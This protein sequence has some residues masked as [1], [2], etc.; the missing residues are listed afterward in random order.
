MK[1][2]LAGILVASAALAAAQLE[3]QQAEFTWRGRLE[4]GQE[5]AIRGVKGNIQALPTSEGEA[6]VSAVKRARRSDPDDVRIE[7]VPHR[8]GVTVCA[9]YPA[10]RRRQPNECLPGGEGRMNTRDNDV[11]VDFTVFVPAGV[12]FVGK[13]VLG[14]V[15]AESLGGWVRAQTVNGDVRVSTGGLAEASTVNGS[16]VAALGRSDWSGRLAFKTVNGGITLALPADLATEVSA[17]TVNGSIDSDFP[18]TVSGRFS[19]RKIRAT[20]GNGGR[21]LDL[22]TVNGSIRLQRAR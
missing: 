14:D 7:V 9:V 16:V 21:E 19:A 17:E 18:L 8:G 6:R 1:P 20:I 3:A 4:R 11:E 12:D 22:A 5:L 15:T 2:C 13:T 10:P